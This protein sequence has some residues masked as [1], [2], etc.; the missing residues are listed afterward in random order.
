MSLY[1]CL[2]RC[3]HSAAPLREAEAWKGGESH[4]LLMGRVGVADHLTKASGRKRRTATPR[5]KGSAMRILPMHGPRAARRDAN[6]AEA[7]MPAPA[8]PKLVCFDAIRGLAAL[9]VVVSHILV[10]FWPAFMYREGPQWDAAPGWVHALVRFPC[11]KLWDGSLAVTI[12]FGLSGFVLS[13]AFLQHVST[14]ALGSAA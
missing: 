14:R 11:G 6:P 3:P 8:A 4:L 5:S 9:M 1:S 10:G 2:L 13:R 7:A 12:V